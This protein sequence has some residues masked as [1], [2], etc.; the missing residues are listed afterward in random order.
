MSGL[1]PYQTIGNAYYRPQADGLAGLRTVIWPAIGF[2]QDQ[3]EI[4]S[5]WGHFGRTRDKAGA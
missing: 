5:F 2:I 3:R 1:V 4:T